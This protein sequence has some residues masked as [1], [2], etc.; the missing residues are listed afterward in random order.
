MELSTA[1]LV[2]HQGNRELG[3][4]YVC[5]S[6]YTA[7]NPAKGITEGSNRRVYY[8]PL[9]PLSVEMDDEKLKKLYSGPALT[10]AHSVLWSSQYNARANGKVL[11]NLVQEG[12]KLMEKQRSKISEVHQM[13]S[14][15]CNFF[16]QCNEFLATCKRLSVDPLKLLHVFVWPLPFNK[17][18]TCFDDGFLAALLGDAAGLCTILRDHTAG[19][20]RVDTHPRA[21]EQLAV[22]ISN[23][24]DNC[25]PSFLLNNARCWPRT[26]RNCQHPL[27]IPS[28]GSCLR[29]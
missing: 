17:D 12:A 1:S 3:A 26:F 21:L 27:V 16:S 23:I 6:A 15:T 19:V 11:R 2:D 20:D 13:P 7:Y 9:P 29:R 10:C 4:L 5:A 24:D 18:T 28:V 8:M 25:V 14:T 22:K